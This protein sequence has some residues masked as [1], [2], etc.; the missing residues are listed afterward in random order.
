V[1]ARAF[2]WP[3]PPL[4]PETDAPI[5][6]FVVDDHPMVREGLRSLLDDEGIEV[7][8]EAA[9]ATEALREVRRVMPDVLLLDV[10]LPDRDGLSTLTELKAA[11]PGMSVLVVT[12]HAERIFVR[13]A[14]AGGAAGYVL[15]GAGRR[16]LLS[17]VR[18]VRAGGSVVDP[19][20][21]RDLANPGAADAR[22][23]LAESLSP[24]ELDVLRGIADG[25]T[26]RQIAERMRWSVATAKKYV[27]RVLEK[28][29]ATDRT[30][31]A[32]A[33]LRA[34]LLD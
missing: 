29:G 19:A 6:V 26:N 24:L 32:V 2:P 11:A 20:L 3:G 17:A 8:G 9:S 13:R 14:I 25:L 1:F 21:L 22:P 10:E 18:A 28:M 16:E 27:Q 5:R 4:S 7:V 33:A 34:R 30:Q 23:L 15:K 12:M 31:A